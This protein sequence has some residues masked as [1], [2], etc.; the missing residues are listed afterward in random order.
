VS[1]TRHQHQKVSKGQGGEGVAKNDERIG[2][3]TGKGGE[4]T[5][6][7]MRNKKAKRSDKEQCPGKGETVG[8]ALEKKVG[9]AG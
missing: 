6:S 7:E 3:S 8:R 9:R 2:Q 1:I 4:E 5:R